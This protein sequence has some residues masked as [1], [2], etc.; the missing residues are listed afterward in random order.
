MGKVHAA[1]KGRILFLTFPKETEA[2]NFIPS[3]KEREKKAAAKI[4]D[5]SKKIQEITVVNTQLKEENQQLKS[6]LSEAYEQLGVLFEI[7]E[8]KG[9]IEVKEEEIEENLVDIPDVKI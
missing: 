3:I 4:N 5:L 2:I 7:A 6:A 9:E 1:Q 8:K